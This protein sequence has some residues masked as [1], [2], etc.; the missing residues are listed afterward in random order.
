M[1]I[2]PKIMLAAVVALTLAA[3]GCSTKGS[4]TTAAK[5]DSNGVKYSTGVTDTTISL[6]VL[7][8]LSGVFK[9]TSEG[10][11]RGHQLWADKVN[12]SGGICGRNINLVT[13]DTVYQADKAVVIYPEVKDKIL[14]IMDLG[15]SQI[16]ATLKSKIVSDKML[17]IP[18]SWASTNLDSPEIMM[19]GG[20]YD[21]EMLNGLSYLKSQGKISNGAKIGHI[22]IDSE[23]GQN[24]LLGS[25]HYAKENGGEVVPIAVTSTDTDMTAA[26]TQLKSVGVTAIAVTLAPAATSSVI[27]QDVAQGLNVPVIG[28]NPSFDAVLLNTPAKQALES[29]YYSAGPVVPFGDPASPKA[30]EVATAYAAKYNTSAPSSNVNVGYLAG[31]S[32]QSLLE[33]ACTNKDLTREGLLAALKK[34]TVDTDGLSPKLNF[35]KPGAPSSRASVITRPDSSVPGGLKTLQPSTESDAAKN[36]TMPKK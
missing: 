22:Y 15:G 30:T 10:Y 19:L 17:T 26:V 27:T 21:I 36:Y 31:L 4:S 11:I 24:G 35:T 8:D 1:N 6:G 5:T 29:L 2:N 18:M 13:R 14:G 34:T 25:Q 9:T 33:K 3:T 32:F 16:L 23:F 7:A 28:N 20:T 12:S